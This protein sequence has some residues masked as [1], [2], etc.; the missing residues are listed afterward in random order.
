MDKDRIAGSAK[1]IKGSIKEVAGKVVGDAKIEAG[2]ESE[3]GRRSRSCEGAAVVQTLVCVPDR[4]HRDVGASI[5]MDIVEAGDTVRGALLTQYGGSAVPF[6]APSRRSKARETAENRG[7]ID[8]G[9]RS[10]GPVR[11]H[12]VSNSPSREQRAKDRD[13]VANT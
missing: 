13:H 4:S 9:E 11:T 6:T 3:T 1:Q 2:S 7:D 10:R 5:R 12:S 8:H